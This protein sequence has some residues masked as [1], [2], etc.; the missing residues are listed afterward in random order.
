MLSQN[1]ALTLWGE[2]CGQDDF[3]PISDFTFSGLPDV[4]LEATPLTDTALDNRKNFDISHSVVWHP[5]GARAAI[6]KVKFLVSGPSPN[7]TF[8]FVRIPSGLNV[9][10]KGGGQRIYCLSDAHLGSKVAMATPAETNVP[11]CF[12]LLGERG[13]M[14]SVRMSILNTDVVIKRDTLWSDE[15]LVQGANSHGIIDLTTGKLRSGTRARIVVN[16]H[17]WIGRR[18]TLMAGCEIGAGSVVGTSAVAVKKYPECTVIVGNPGVVAGR[19]R[20]WVNSIY[21]TKDIEKQFIDQH[22]IVE[23]PPCKGGLDWCRVRLQHIWRRVTDSLT[24]R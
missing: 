19:H 1:S 23:P 20:T 24:R 16:E 15:I 3:G 10:L 14:A 8:V 4:A 13:F 17:V 11:G 2:L 12:L 18:A 9:I 6:R 7:C 21:K 5:V 22:M